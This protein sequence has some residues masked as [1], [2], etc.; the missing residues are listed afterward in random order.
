MVSRQAD[1]KK[2]VYI[3]KNRIFSVLTVL[4]TVILVLI[5]SIACFF[6]Y[7]QKEEELLSQM[8]MTFVRLEQ[9]YL[10][11]IN[12]FWK[13]YM[14]LYESH[15]NFHSVL[16]DYFIS[17]LDKPL[18]P[19]KK[20]ELSSVLMQ[21]MLRDEQV[22]WIALYSEGRQYNYILYRNKNLFDVLPDDFP[23]LN[24]L[25]SKSGMEIY[26]ME[27][28]SDGTNLMNT[29]AICG[30][31]PSNI[32]NGSIIA[33]YSISELEYICKN[34]GSTI[35]SLNYMLLSNGEILFDSSGSYDKEHLYLPEGN[36]TG[37]VIVPDSS[38]KLYVRSE[39]IGKNNSLLSYTVSWPEMF[40]YSHG[41]TLYILSIVLVF[42][43]LSNVLY[44]VMLR[45]ISREV[46]TIRYGLK[47][48]GENNLDYRIPTNFNQGG[49]SE[50]AE[51]INHMALMLKNNINRAYYYEIRQKEAELSE[52]QAKF[53]PHFLYNSLEMLRFRCHKNGDSD[54]ANL[55]T[56][57][58]A[59]FRGFIGSRTFI[60]LQEELAF[61]KRYVALFGARY[62][63]KVQVRY[64]IDTDV[65]KYG[66]IRNVFQPLIENYFVHGF[67][68]SIENNYILF[69]GRSLDE[70]T[71]MISLEDNGNGMSDEDI[72]QLNTSLQEPIKIDTDSYGLKNLHQRLHLFYGANCGLT[73]TKNGEKGLALQMVLLKMTCEEY[74]QSKVAK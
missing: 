20:R 62:G 10:N 53:N 50:V 17:D 61:S 67:D 31:A 63:D 57:L 51:S 58:S 27:T 11:S 48:I 68:A 44:T 19:L 21:M 37:R 29:Y 56:Q 52:L 18:E 70:K 47:K 49:L 5:S 73:I 71:M 23:Y 1:I 15:N 22:Q 41:Y 65:L 26:G 24:K 55:I 14:P 6:A 72:Q 32:L 9:K 39:L 42:G 4:Y 8:D 36:I 43:L 60:P 33:G 3:T 54:T 30:G 69:R 64:D 16:A 12:N 13:I 45:L 38:E 46:Y 28:I 59:I 2:N 40:R 25:T 7:G 35:E 34:A 74:E 66:I